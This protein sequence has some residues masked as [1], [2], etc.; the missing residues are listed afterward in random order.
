MQEAN[1][2]KRFEDKKPTTYNKPNPRLFC[3]AFGF[4]GLVDALTFNH[5]TLEK[6]Q[7]KSPEEDEELT[8]IML[9]TL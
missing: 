9:N 6:T 2:K 3:P 5:M 1:E 4:A 8:R 7:I